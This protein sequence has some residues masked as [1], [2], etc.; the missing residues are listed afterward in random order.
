[1]SEKIP[2]KLEDE[3]KNIINE[4]EWNEAV[5]YMDTAP[6]E[7]ALSYKNDINKLR[8]LER[9]IKKY[10]NI[11]MFYNKPFTYLRIS[12]WKYFGCEGKDPEETWLINRAKI[13]YDDNYKI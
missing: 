3:L 13:K 8:K 11:E 6:H 5:T 2:R 10:G 12:E 9:A 4:L 7:Y 1:M